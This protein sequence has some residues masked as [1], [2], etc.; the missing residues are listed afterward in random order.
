MISI[1]QMQPCYLANIF[2]LGTSIAQMK[3]ILFGVFGYLDA[4]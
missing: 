1:M 4:D 2:A 3:K